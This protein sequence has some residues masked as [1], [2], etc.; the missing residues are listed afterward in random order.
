MVD[1][2]RSSADDLDSWTLGNGLRLLVSEGTGS[3]TT[4]LT[5]LDLFL[6]FFL[7]VSRVVVVLE[8]GGR[9]A[10]SGW[11]WSRTSWSRG[12]W[13]SGVVLWN[14]L[15]GFFLGFLLLFLAAV[16]VVGVTWVS[17]HVGELTFVT[18][19]VNVSVLASDNAIR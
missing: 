9:W 1:G 14:V 17:R 11:N 2:V 15:V 7:V 3:W 10:R 19:W 12:N 13:S 4:T 16:W 6:G 8:D 5:D 18:V